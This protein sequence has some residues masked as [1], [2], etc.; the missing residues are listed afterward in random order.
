[1]RYL[2]VFRMEITFSLACALFNTTPHPSQLSS[3]LTLLGWRR[4]LK[5]QKQRNLWAEKSSRTGQKKTPRG[6]SAHS[7]P[8]GWWPGSVPAPLSPCSPSEHGSPGLGYPCA[9]AVP[10]CVP[11][12]L[13]PRGK[14]IPDSQAQCSSL[15][16]GFKEVQWGFFGCGICSLSP[17]L[18]LWF[19]VFVSLVALSEVLEA[20]SWWVEETQGSSDVSPARHSPARLIFSE[21]ATFSSYKLISL[22]GVIHSFNQI[23]P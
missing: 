17:V 2:Q 4:E 1:M 7:S 20:D 3:L 16:T 11:S 19:Q 21:T 23:C 14:G 9:R 18:P 6:G 22:H 15:G 8:A 13:L 5:Q 10:G 12:A